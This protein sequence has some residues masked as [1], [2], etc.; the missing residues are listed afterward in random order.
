MSAASQHRLDGDKR[1]LVSASLRATNHK[2]RKLK[3]L[4][5]TET[6]LRLTLLC[7]NNQ[8]D[9]KYIVVISPS[10]CQRHMLNNKNAS[11]WR[12][13]LLLI[14]VGIVVKHRVL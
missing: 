14:G 4:A 10:C 12:C 8:T 9:E 7:V 1:S 2:S 11:K 3:E 6:E 5:V 13:T